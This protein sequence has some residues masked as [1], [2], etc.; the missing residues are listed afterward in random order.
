MCF[1]VTHCIFRKGLDEDQ[2]NCLREME[3]NTFVLV[4]FP[5]PAFSLLKLFEL[6]GKPFIRDFPKNMNDECTRERK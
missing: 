1:F 5:L 4:D 6:I 2:R 3:I